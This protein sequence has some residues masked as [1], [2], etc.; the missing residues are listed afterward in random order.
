MKTRAL[1]SRVILMSS[2]VLV[3]NSFITANALSWQDKAQKK[4][5]PDAEAKAIKALEA[6]V[7]VNAKFL[8]AEEF[9][10]KYPSSKVRPQL[11]QYLANQVFALTDS[12]QK[13]A[14]G[15]KYIALFT[16]PTEKKL[17]E[18]A[19][20]DAYIQLKRFDEG[21]DTGAGYLSNDSDDVQVRALLAIAGAELAR[22]QNVKYLKVS[23]EYGAKAIELIEADK[24]PAAM[25]DDFW[26]REKAL[27]PTLYQQ[28][29]I[30]SLVGQELADATTK[31]EKAVQLNPT[32]PFNYALLGSITNNDY[33]ALAMKLRG[34]PD[35][36]SKQEMLLKANQTLDK[37][38]EQ[39]A[40][41]AALT[42]GKPQFQPLRDQVM[43]DLT[44]YYK[45]RHNNSVDGLQK[46]IDGYK[47]P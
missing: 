47:V 23:K 38:I 30:I 34:M 9:V 8:A 26:L 5:I 19:L 3:A 4:T 40:R 43:E 13:L 18:P 37:V 25:E 20:V 2:L 32:D 29:G 45:Y 33:Q 27:L 10:K 44:T 21:F 31:L 7:D 42:E 14:I 35:S 16:A 39:Y 36:P 24:K 1:L 41:A 17:V 46:Y 22:G 15:Q 12:T 6:G 28:M 11:A